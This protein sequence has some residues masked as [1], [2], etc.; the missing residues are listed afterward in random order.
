MRQPF[1]IRRIDGKYPAEQISSSF[2][3]YGVIVLKEYMSRNIRNTL[4]NILKAKL[5][6]SRTRGNVLKYDK[7]PSADFLLGDVLSIRELEEYDYVF[8]N[9]ELVQVLKIML[10]SKEIIYYSDSNIQFDAAERGF[11]KDNTERY[12]ANSDDWIGDY[13]LLRAG[14]YCEDHVNHSG[15]LKVRLKSHK[16]ENSRSKLNPNK[17]SA[18][19]GRSIDIK[20][21]FGDLLIWS[22]RLTHSGNYKKIKLLPNISVHPRL[23][24][25]LPKYL[26]APEQERRNAMFCSFGKPGKHLDSYIKKFDSRGPEVRRYLETARRPEEVVSYLASRGITQIKPTEY[27]GV[28][29][30]DS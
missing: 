28:N 2:N 17:I 7:Y 20:S 21:E 25:I 3:K 30:N 18:H 23:E 15:G 24:K 26:V 22:M 12:D 11:H 13:G 14:F 10:C 1:E 27:V 8:F 29:D 19:A 4:R 5:E 9:D 6:R 16:L